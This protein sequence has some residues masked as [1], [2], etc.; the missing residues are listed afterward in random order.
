MYM[1]LFR[2]ICSSMIHIYIRA[3]SACIHL[4]MCYICVYT[5]LTGVYTL[6]YTYLH[7]S[8]RQIDTSVYMDSLYQHIY[9]WIFIYVLLLQTIYFHIHSLF[10]DIYTF[11]CTY[12]HCNNRHIYTHMDIYALLMDMPNVIST[13]HPSLKD[14]HTAHAYSTA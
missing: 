7:S 12:T 8:Y 13:L 1:Y 3:L 10:E 4:Y 9:T 6:T 5:F 2:L 11:A 14:K